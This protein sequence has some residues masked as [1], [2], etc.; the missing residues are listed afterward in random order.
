MGRNLAYPVPVAMSATE[1]SRSFGM[2]GWMMW[3]SESSTRN[4]CCALSLEM[5]GSQS[6]LSSVG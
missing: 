4:L 2:D 1:K 6:V 5:R 3:L